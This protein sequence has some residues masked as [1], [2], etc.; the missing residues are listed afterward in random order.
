MTSAPDD[1]SF[2]LGLQRERTRLAWNR[3]LEALVVG[4]I[5]VTVDALKTGRGAP[6]LIG[7]ALLGVTVTLALWQWRTSYERHGHPMTSP[8]QRL[9]LTT[10]GLALLA[11]GGVLM[12]LT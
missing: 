4:Q 7:L 3:T 2:W 1:G 12:V 8:A 6:A 11:L 9:A 10:A 5:V